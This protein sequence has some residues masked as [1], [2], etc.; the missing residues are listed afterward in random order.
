[1]HHKEIRAAQGIKLTAND[2]EQAVAGSQLY[3]YNTEEE[4]KAFSEELVHE[5]TEVKKRIKLSK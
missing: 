4:L 3:V 5:F 1:L 2:L